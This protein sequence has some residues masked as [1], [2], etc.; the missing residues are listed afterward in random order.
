MAGFLSFADSFCNQS[1]IY[2]DRH[3]D[4][5]IPGCLYISAMTVEER[6]LPP[7]IVKV[8]SLGGKLLCKAD[9]AFCLYIP[10]MDHPSVD[11]AQY[12]DE[13]FAFDAKRPGALL[14][15]CQAGISRS[16]SVVIGILI[17][18]YHKSLQD[19]TEMLL[20]ARPG[21]H[22]NLSF[23]YQLYVWSALRGQNNYVW[24]VQPRTTQAEAAKTR[25]KTI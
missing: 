15:N 18:G 20:R 25:A 23:Q 12:F 11:I 9:S 1:R 4:E 13:I 19:A 8:V 2:P 22:P 3:I 16:A 6:E 5:V 14:V 24:N 17:A 10:V 21:V 7:N